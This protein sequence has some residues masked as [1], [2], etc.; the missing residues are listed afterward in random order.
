MIIDKS[1]KLHLKLLDL[2][3]LGDKTIEFLVIMSFV[4]E[5][6]VTDTFSRCY[7]KYVLL[8]NGFVI[9]CYHECK[10]GLSFISKI[11]IGQD[12]ILLSLKNRAQP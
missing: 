10:M 1:S 12:I 7:S 5:N 4:I 9:V 8:F 6:T 3:D 2:Y 11:K